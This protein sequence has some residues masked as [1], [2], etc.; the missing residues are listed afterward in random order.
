MAPV[1]KEK[2]IGL[3]TDLPDRLPEILGD[4]ESLLRVFTNIIGNATKYTPENGGIT[5]AAMSDDYYVT[6]RISDTGTGIPADKL[7]FIFEPFYRVRGKEE[8]QGGS[9]LG[10]TFC[11]KIMELHGGEISVESTEGMG[12]T[13]L[14]KF[15]PH[16]RAEQGVGNA[17]K[18]FR[19]F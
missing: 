17:A 7:P 5:L 4:Q 1:C 6:V 10:L 12:S 11:R 19:P 8:R 13:F 9:G 3:K 14:L 15:L 2:G 18:P 16:V